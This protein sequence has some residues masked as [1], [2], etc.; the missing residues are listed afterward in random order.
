MTPCPR[1]QTLR[2]RLATATCA[3]LVL[4]VP[5]SGRLPVDVTS[6]QTA[7]IAGPVGD[8]AL[9]FDARGLTGLAA[10]ARLLRRAGAG[11]GARLGVVLKYRVEGGDWL[12]LYQNDP[13]KTAPTPETVVYANDVD[14]TVLKS[15]QTFRTDGR[16]LDWTIDVA[17]RT[18]EPIEVGD[19]ALSLPWRAPGGED[20]DAIFERSWTKHQFI[21]GHGSF[22][23]FVRPNGEPPYLVVTTLPGT[24][25]EYSTSPGGRGSGFLA[26]VHSALTGGA[27]TRGTWRQPHT[28]LML[29]PAGTPSAAVRYGLRFRWAQSYDE[30]RAILY[31]EGLFDMR[32]VPG[33]T[34][35][36]RPGRAVLAPHEGARRKHPRGIPGRHNHHPAR[37]AAARPLPLSRPLHPP[38]RE[39]PHHRPRRR[40]R[41]A[42]RVLRHRTA[43]DARQEAGAF[44][45]VAPAAPRPGEVVRRP[46]LGLRHAREG[47][48][49]ARR[50]R[51][52]RLLVGLRRRGR[53]PGVGQGAV[54]RVEER[55]V[56]GRGARLR[57]SSTTWSTSSGGSCSAPTR[58]RRI[59]GACTACPTGA[60]RATRSCACARATP[61]SRR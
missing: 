35:P 56:P 61:T 52:L 10:T 29:G 17:N 53:R 49:L 45:R 8:F 21:S 4:S 16:V 60:R 26:F 50:H 48:A 55:A 40:A 18:Q 30:M 23:Y 2:L 20:P 24:K 14:G 54:P 11:A 57:P 27:E 42:S 41:D 43:R 5:V 19:F 46:L 3:A 59:R 36:E 9:S 38:R 37:R 25:L 33:M 47:A 1:F 51:R 6:G 7:S 34:V 12:D 44:P 58:R 22:L 39:P 28:N 32:V 15:A 31:D 13:V